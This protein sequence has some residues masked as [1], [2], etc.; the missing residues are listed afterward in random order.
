M[1]LK[2]TTRKK[3]R[4]VS[5]DFEGVEA[6]GRSCP[7]GTYEAEITSVTEEESSAGNDMLVAKWKV[8]SGKGK[9]AVIWDNLSLTPQA[10]WRLKGLLEA[11]E[12]EVPDGAMDLDIEDLVGKTATI[13]ITN[14]TYEGK[15]R[16]RITGYGS[17]GQAEGEQEETEEEDEKP[18]K[19]S[20]KKAAKKD[21]EEE[22]PEEEAEEE[23]ERPTKKKVASKKIREGSKVKFDDGEGNIIRATVLEIDGDTARCEDKSGD[24]YE[25][26]TDDLEAV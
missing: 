15:Q 19:K 25:V 11:L 5:V 26:N 21:E 9:G 2:K 6:G 4:T 7:D 14:E 20:A 16:P 10:L 1:A 17:E 22:E 3:G 8:L 18:A 13:E 12:I 24:E 23:E